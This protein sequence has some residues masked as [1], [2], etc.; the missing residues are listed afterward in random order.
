MFSASSR[1]QTSRCFNIALKKLIINVC[2]IYRFE[3]CTYTQLPEVKNIAFFTNY[4]RW[5]HYVFTQYYFYNILLS[6]LSPFKIRNNT[7]LAYTD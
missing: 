2:V 1:N 5:I 4:V 7:Q 3:Y 6:E